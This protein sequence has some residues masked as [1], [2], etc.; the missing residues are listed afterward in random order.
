MDFETCADTPTSKR[1]QSKAANRTAILEAG[2]RVFARIGFEATTVRDIIRET[3]LAAGTFY[4]YFKSKEQVFAAIAEDSTHRFRHQMAHVRESTTSLEDYIRAAYTTY[5]SFIAEENIEAIA[6]GAPHIALIG[7]RIDTP[8]MEA[9]TDEIRMD[10]ERVLG[11]ASAPDLD[12]EYLTAAA[13]GIARE[14]GDHMLKRRPVD[15]EAAARFATQLLL[16]G[17]AAVTIP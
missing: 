7:V 3:D 5:F 17:A 2:R 15:A 6:G 8:E 1:A 10:I 13:V 12:T 16:A 14:M 9:V 4:N 11:N